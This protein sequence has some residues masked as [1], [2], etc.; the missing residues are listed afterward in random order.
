MKR[1]GF[2][3]VELFVVLAIVA[4]VVALITCGSGCDKLEERNTPKASTGVKK[5]QAQVK[6]GA[7]GLTVEQRN[8][9]ARYKLENTPGSVKHLYVISAYSGDVILYS[10]VKGKVTSSGKRLTPYAV[11]CT[12]GQYVSKANMGVPVR[13]GDKVYR[14]PEVLQDD[15]TYG[16]SIQYLYW[17]DSKGLYHQHYV[18]GGQI[19]HIADQPIVTNKIILNLEIADAS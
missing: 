17:F 6:T 13:V 7:D 14:T 8:I 12:D 10:T 1:R 2:T 9:K 16:H 18:N 3:I 15:G 19:V 11:G 5:A 4:I